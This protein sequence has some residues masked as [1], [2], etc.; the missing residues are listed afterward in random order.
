[1]IDGDIKK[2]KA[3]HTSG[4]SA[5][6]K[7]IKKKQDYFPVTSIWNKENNPASLKHSFKPLF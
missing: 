5:T 6:A 7:Y 1:M 4:S 2:Q 3:D